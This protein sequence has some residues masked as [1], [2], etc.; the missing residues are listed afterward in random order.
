MMA[1]FSGNSRIVR[2]LY[3]TLLRTAKK[4]DDNVAAKSILFR[5]STQLNN[6]VD[7][8][9]IYYNGI[10]KSIFGEDGGY[11]LNLHR[12][13]DVS[14][15]DIVRKEFH[16]DNSGYKESERID[17]AFAVVRKFSSIWKKYERVM[18]SA[19]AIDEI[20]EDNEEDEAILSLIESR[21]DTVPL[22]LSDKVSSGTLLMAH[23][24]VHGDLQRSIILV[25]DTSPK[26]SYGVVI[27]NLT[28]I[29]LSHGVKNLPSELV[30]IFGRKVLFQGG[31]VRRLQCIHKIPNI[32]GISIPLS[33]EPLYFGGDV[34]KLL[35]QLRHNPE[36]ADQVEFFAGCC[37]WDAGIL[38]NEIKKGYWIPVETFPDEVLFF[39]KHMT[40]CKDDSSVEDIDPSI[41]KISHKASLDEKEAA[42]MNELKELMESKLGKEI[43]SSTEL[44]GD[45]INNQVF[46]EVKKEVIVGE[47][48][49]NGETLNA[50]SDV[51]TVVDDD[52]DDFDD[53]Y[54]DDRYQN[55]KG[56]GRRRTGKVLHRNH[57]ANETD[58]YPSN[59]RHVDLNN[60]SDDDSDAEST[61][62]LIG[63]FDYVDDYSDND[64]EIDCVQVDLWNWCMTRTFKG[65]FAS[66]P[67]W[68]ATGS[69]ESV[70]W[71]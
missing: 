6:V 12:A 68:A 35:D 55:R 45:K 25:L 29:T 63:D 65:D 71:D 43:G 62:S 60:I 26:G 32:G 47:E 24:M 17:G 33:K 38:E 54:D 5:K 19:S 48:V 34:D 15:R 41:D 4:Y 28:D 7:G 53:E 23:P 46:E 40:S 11:F 3:R 44:I 1:N 61:I 51:K 31:I 70:D 14:F 59:I 8:A 13:E 27:S 56:Y 30:R 67:P 50:S 9:S 22:K 42:L 69:V 57:E 2:S 10:M 36:L 52:N 16:A 21:L 49:L 64:F 39:S 20:E 37:V 66:L 58:R 18:E